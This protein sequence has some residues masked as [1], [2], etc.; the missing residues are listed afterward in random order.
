M[1]IWTFIKKHSK[2]IFVILGFFSFFLGGFIVGQMKEKNGQNSLLSIIYPIREKEPSHPFIFPLLD[3]R[4]P[5]SDTFPEYKELKDDLTKYVAQNGR[6]DVSVYF[7][8]STKG[9]WVGIAE[10]EEFVPASLLKV[11]IMIAYL[12][13]AET[14]PSVLNRNYTYESYM[15]SLDDD[16]TFSPPL[17]LHVGASYKVSDLIE[18]MIS[19]SDNGA[20]TVL[21]AHVD[22]S[23]LQ[24][25]YKDLGL[26]G[27]AE[28]I[29][30]TISAR[31]Y[32]L[33][34]R[35]LYNT[36][37]LSRDMSN[38]A[39][40]LLSTG[41]FDD[42]LRKGIPDTIPIA[43]KFG[44]HVESVSGIMT[45]VEL[46]DCGIIYYPNRNYF[47]CVMTRGKTYQDVSTVIQDINKI[48]YT[49][50]D[51]EEKKNK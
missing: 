43:H 46:H 44:E 9:R 1:Q 47:L 27:P 50:I 17:E 5:E 18:K 45:G 28:N 21:L 6:G 11:V 31:Q 12:K 41:E 19:L 2:P 20:K 51:T 3:Y 25:V 24:E 22:D 40:L 16:D 32:S 39:L 10:D 49:T 37:Y 26:S 35:I 14:N 38:K 8:D 34:F 4:L 29:Q 13:K 30:F 42:G 15:K 7:R 48:V 23:F 33:F 36:T